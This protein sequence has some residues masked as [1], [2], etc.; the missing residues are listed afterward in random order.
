MKQYDSIVVGSGFGGMGAALQLGE[1]G[2]N[3][4]LLE[5][6]K[7]PGGCASTFEKQGYRFEAGATLFSGFAEGQ[8]FHTWKHR[9]NMNFEFQ[10]HHPTISFATSNVSI[11]IYPERDLVIQQFCDIPHAPI[12]KI[13]K[14]FAIQ[15]EIADVLWPIFDSPNRLP[16]FDWKSIWWHIRRL[17]KYTSVWKW[18]N[19]SLY[20]VIVYC[21]LEDFEP[22]L[23]YCNAISQI[24]IQSN[25]WDCEAPFALATLDYV[26]RGTGHILGGVGVL[27]RE[28]CRAIEN[29]NGEV[30]FSNRV[31]TLTREDNQWIVT[32]RQGSFSCQNV[33]LNLLPQDV[34]KLLLQ[35]E[36][37]IFEQKMHSLISQVSG[38]WGAVMLYLILEEQD[39]F[40]EEA[41]HFQAV[42]DEQ[43]AFQEGNH[44]FCSMSSRQESQDPQ[45][46]EN[47]QNMSDTYKSPV[48]QRV[49]TVST[50][51]D[52]SKLRS[53]HKED[54]AIYIHNIQ[55][56][57]KR[58]LQVRFPAIYHAII[59]GFP[60][61]PRTFERFTKR[62]MGLVGGIPK[63][64]GWHNYKNVISSEI[65]EGLW[66][67]GD[68]VFPGQST[69]A[70][71]LG[72]ARTARSICCKNRLI[73]FTSK[74]ILVKNM[75]N[76]EQT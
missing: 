27:A 10:L 50:H 23:H 70:T 41:R 53:L 38:G 76:V 17:S 56:K 60:A 63:S 3:V 7:Y 44:I 26:F 4:L 67:V 16:P 54:Q 20:D 42:L 39:G 15:K 43:K 35:K 11:D 33:V 74:P 73:Q 51:V 19:R 71:A 40:S 58:T 59:R 9:H 75:K 55:K 64:K 25:I 46:T 12:A 34:S 72:G 8:L 57:M 49:A 69:L 18:I 28:M 14:F 31:K 21:G 45:N 62:S 5:A 29:C 30:Q 68:S 65:L 52:L 6:L 36:S 66:L 48:G 47:L 61:S 37:K 2:Q 22:L 32:T 24:T 13:Q 1:L